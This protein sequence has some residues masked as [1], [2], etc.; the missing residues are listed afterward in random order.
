MIQTFGNV[1]VGTY[2]ILIVL[3]ASILGIPNAVLSVFTGILIVF[4]VFLGWRAIRS[5]D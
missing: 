3:P 2:N 1:I 5:G 4:M